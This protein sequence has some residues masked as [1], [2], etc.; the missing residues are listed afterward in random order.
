LNMESKWGFKDAAI[1]GGVLVL[2]FYVA[3]KVR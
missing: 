2:F 1:V 3:K